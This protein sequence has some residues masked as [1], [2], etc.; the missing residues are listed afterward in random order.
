MGNSTT[1]VKTEFGDVTVRKMPLADYAEM[2]K[3]LDTIPESLMAFFGSKDNKELKSTSNAEFA[4]MLPSLLATCWP[5][6]I[7]VVA[8]PTDK[9]KEFM[10]KLDLADA[11]DVVGAIVELNNIPRIIAAVKKA[12]AL[13]DKIAEQPAS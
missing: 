6:L 7:G 3:A 8:V 1:I 4:L 10:A 9:D 13:K 5:D 2:L 11:V 12:V